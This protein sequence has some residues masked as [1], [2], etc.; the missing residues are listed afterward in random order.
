MMKHYKTAVILGYRW[1][2]KS[3]GNTY[4]VVKIA[5]TTGEAMK[6]LITSDRFRYGGGDQYRQTAHELLYNEGYDA[7][8]TETRDGRSLFIWD[9]R[10]N[11]DVFDCDCR[12]D[13]LAYV[14]I[15][16]GNGFLHKG[17]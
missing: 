11:F 10:N 16:G 4:H 12:R 7:P 8:T 9:E 1:H 15:Y 13:A 6:T 14:G 2:E 5:L 3:N 17:K